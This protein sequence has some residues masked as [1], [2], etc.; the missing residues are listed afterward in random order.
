M[1][2]ARDE[3]GAPVLVIE[4]T[5][6]SCLVRDPVTGDRRS[7]PRDR[8]APLDE[9]PLRTAAR[10][11]PD[12]VRRL[13][14][15]VPHDRALGLLLI[16]EDEPRSVP[17]LA[18]VCEICESDLHGLLGELRAAGLVRETTVDGTPGYRT[19]DIATAGIASLD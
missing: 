11:V 3:T 6:D 13:L 10:A 5:A 16:L 1:R 8:L 15:A 14:T 7:V 2:N 17:E 18:T 12:P 4:E 9:P 19:T